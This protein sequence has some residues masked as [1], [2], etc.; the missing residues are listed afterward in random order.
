MTDDETAT[1]AIVK[2]YATADRI[3]IRKHARDRMA[4]RSA[5]FV[6]IRSALVTATDLLDQK[7]G[8]FK[9]SGGVDTDGDALAVVVAIEGQV[10]VVTLF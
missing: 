8:R 1:L 7:D 10:V 2:T 6:D 9:V 3:S 4:E 5:R